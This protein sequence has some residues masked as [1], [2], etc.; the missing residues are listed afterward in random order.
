MTTI[1]FS[2]ASTPSYWLQEAA[3]NS[4]VWS[5]SLMVIDFPGKQD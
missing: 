5:A 3:R 1:F 2:T 4:S